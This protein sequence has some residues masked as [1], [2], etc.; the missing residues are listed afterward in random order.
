MDAKILLDQTFPNG[1]DVAFD[2][3][4]FWTGESRMER[5]R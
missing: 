5:S 3:L 1:R 2:G 4:F